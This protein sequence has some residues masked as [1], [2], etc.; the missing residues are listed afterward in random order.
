MQNESAAQAAGTRSE[1]SHTDGAEDA[2]VISISSLS[3]SEEQRV[4]QADSVRVDRRATRPRGRPVTLAASEDRS[5][6][7]VAELLAMLEEKDRLLAETERRREEEVAESERKRKESERRLKKEVAELQ[8]KSKEEVAESER[9]RKESERTQRRLKNEVAESER[10]RKEA[11]KRLKAVM[12]ANVESERKWRDAVAV[13]DAKYGE[14]FREYLHERSRMQEELRKC[15]EKLAHFKINPKIL[16]TSAL[17]CTEDLTGLNSSTSRA[18][19]RVVV[20]W[21]KELEGFKDAQR[22][23]TLSILP[24][25]EKRADVSNFPE[26][27]LPWGER[28]AGSERDPNSIL[29]YTTFFALNRLLEEVTSSS[30]SLGR[31]SINADGATYLSEELRLLLLFELKRHNL[32]K[33][34]LNLVRNCIIKIQNLLDRSVN[35][36]SLDAIQQLVGYMSLPR[37]DTVSSPPTSTG[38]L[39]SLVRTALSASLRPTAGTKLASALCWPC[40]TT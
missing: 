14:L 24:E 33:N 19:E 4:P 40:C 39:W 34:G 20:K 36:D 10:M 8:R 2:L 25:V 27:M 11:E 6:W 26:G 31:F 21:V 32:T 18:S 1:D 35:I 30:V 37:S 9:K 5:G 28:K 15:I 13:K 7:Q 12:D 22:K 23:F 3:I 17:P 16:I 29:D 38:G